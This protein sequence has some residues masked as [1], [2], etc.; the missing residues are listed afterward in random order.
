MAVESDEEETVEDE[1][2]NLDF[3]T[4]AEQ[5][6]AAARRLKDETDRKVRDR[7]LML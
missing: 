6:K 7:T 1:E 3:L 2:N 5:T 4:L